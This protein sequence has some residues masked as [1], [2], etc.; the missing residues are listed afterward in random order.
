MGLIKGGFQ[1]ILQTFLYILLFL[2]AAIILGV[3]SY[4]SFTMCDTRLM[5]IHALTRLNN[6][7]SL[8]W[9][10]PTTT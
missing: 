5:I 7:S 2:C 9:R 3:Y 10:A 6:S 8:S 4:V 1:R